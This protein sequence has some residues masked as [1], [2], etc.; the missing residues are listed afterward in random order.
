MNW[1]FLLKRKAHSINRS[2]RHLALPQRTLQRRRPQEFVHPEAQKRREVRCIAVRTA[3]QYDFLERES[4]ARM[5]MDIRP[6]E[7]VP[8]IFRDISKHRAAFR[9][10]REQPPAKSAGR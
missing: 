8:A 2:A 6:K 10:H 4:L 7:D 3:R 5:V 9:P 1:N